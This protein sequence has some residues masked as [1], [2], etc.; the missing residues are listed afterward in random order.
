MEIKFNMAY[1]SV[2]PTFGKNKKFNSNP[3]KNS[4]VTNSHIGLTK[5][6]AETKYS[7]GLNSKNLYKVQGNILHHIPNISFGSEA[8]LR[9]SEN[10]SRIDYGM[11]G[12]LKSGNITYLDNRLAVG[13]A[14]GSPYYHKNKEGLVNSYEHDDDILDKDIAFLKENG[15]STIIDV[16]HPKY[17]GCKCIESEEAA[18]SKH[19]VRYV[20]IPL[21]SA[22]CP[23]NEQLEKLIS[24]IDNSSGKTYI[25][26]HA[27]KDRTGIA[28]S[29]YLVLNGSTVES[30]LKQVFDERPDLEYNKDHITRLRW[31]NTP[32]HACDK[33]KFMSLLRA[34]EFAVK[35]SK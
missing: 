25:H 17:E 11:Q 20:N 2:I 18:C 1:S 5:F 16:R 32:D 7:S 10:N 28:A 9:A 3:V 14:P 6:D 19:G 22:I 21:D 27:G 15:I 26:C 12:E 34:T 33:D 24:E 30:A 23:T 31:M 4:F 8:I 13:R 29:Y 35:Y